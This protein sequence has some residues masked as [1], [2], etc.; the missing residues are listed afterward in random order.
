MLS[1]LSYY[2]FSDGRSSTLVDP[3]S[4]LVSDSPPQSMAF[5]FPQSLCG[6]NPRDHPV[7]FFWLLWLDSRYVSNESILMPYVSDDSFFR[8]RTLVRVVVWRLLISHVSTR[9]GVKLLRL[10]HHCANPYFH[11][12]LLHSHKC[13]LAVVYHNIRASSTHFR[14]ISPI[15]WH[16]TRP[17]PI[18]YFWALFW[19][20]SGHAL[21]SNSIRLSSFSGKFVHTNQWSACHYQWKRAVR[22][23]IWIPCKIRRRFHYFI[24]SRQN[25]YCYVFLWFHTSST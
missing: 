9:R 16:A 14:T 10:F 19:S 23:H 21:P 13:Q 8:L 4:Q 1:F 5:L 12:V 11:N 6:A 7:T 25:S 2:L 24:Q 22:A 20:S 3:L 18:S 15:S 17:M